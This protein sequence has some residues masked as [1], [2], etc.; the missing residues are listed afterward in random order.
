MNLGFLPPAQNLYINTFG[1]FEIIEKFSEILFQLEVDD[2]IFAF[3]CFQLGSVCGM[4]WGG[5][6]HPCDTDAFLSRR[7]EIIACYVN[8]FY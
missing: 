1:L 6:H 8:T 4:G 7:R 2:Q 3:I 5:M